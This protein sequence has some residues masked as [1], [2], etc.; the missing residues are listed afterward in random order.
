MSDLVFE[1]SRA[2]AVLTGSVRA[3]GAFALRATQIS[4]GVLRQGVIDCYWVPGP[5]GP[6]LT[7]ILH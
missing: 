5:I 2:A 4:L 6:E 3:H 7:I 1:V